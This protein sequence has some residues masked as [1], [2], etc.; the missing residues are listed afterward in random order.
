MRP[1]LP[2]AVTAGISDVAAGVDVHG[3]IDVP[4]LNRVRVSLGM[5]GY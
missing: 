4:K 1:K 3:E 2:S 5:V